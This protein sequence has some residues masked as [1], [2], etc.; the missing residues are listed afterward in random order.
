M[1]I[2]EQAERVAY[3]SV[4]FSEEASAVARAYLAEHRADDDMVVDAAWLESCDKVDSSMLRNVKQFEIG[5]LVEIAAYACSGPECWAYEL[6][7]GRQRIKV[8]PTRGDL[9]RLC[10]ALCVGL[11]EGGR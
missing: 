6:H 10:A 11:G 1:T 8:R 3:G 9:R 2:R 5:G 4:V 7:A